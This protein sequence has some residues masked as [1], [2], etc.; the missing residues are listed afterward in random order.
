MLILVERISNVGEGSKDVTAKAV[1]DLKIVK[2]NLPERPGGQGLW[3]R[4]AFVL[5]AVLLF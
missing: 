3:K 4:V 2:L 5:A 1:E